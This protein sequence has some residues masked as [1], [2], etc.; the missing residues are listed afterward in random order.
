MKV[1]N[2]PKKKVHSD[3]FLKTFEQR[4]EL[5]YQMTLSNIDLIPE[6]KIEN[7]KKIGEG[8]EATVY[9]AIYDGEIVAIKTYKSGNGMEESKKMLFLKNK[10]ILEYKRSFYREINNQ[11]YF[12]SMLEY[13]EHGSL[14]NKK[15]FISESILLKILED[16][17][18][19]LK[20][21]HVDKNVIH[22]DIKPDNILIFNY[23]EICDVNAKLSDFGTCD[24][25]VHEGNSGKD[26]GTPFFMAPEVVK[27]ETYTNKCDIYSFGITML[28]SFLKNELKESISDNPQ[29]NGTYIK[30][31][32]HIKA[33]IRNLIIKCCQINPLK[34]PD[35][36]ECLNSIQKISKIID[37]KE[38]FQSTHVKE[39]DIKYSLPKFD[40]LE[41]IRNVVQS[42]KELKVTNKLIK[43]LLMLKFNIQ[44]KDALSFLQNN[45]VS[46]ENKGDGDGD[47]A[48]ACYYLKKND[49]NLMNKVYKLMINAASKS[50]PNAIMY[51]IDILID[52]V[53][54]KITIYDEEKNQICK[55]INE[56]YDLQLFEIKNRIKNSIQQTNN[57]T[58]STTLVITIFS[59]L[60]KYFPLCEFRYGIVLLHGI[61][62]TK[63][64][65]SAKSIFNSFK[66][67]DYCKDP[68]E[69]EFYYSYCKFVK[70]NNDTYKEAHDMLD[71]CVTYSK[72]Q[73]YY[74]D[75]LNNKGVLLYEGLN[76]KKDINKAFEYFK[77]SMKLNNDYGRYNYAFCLLAHKQILTTESINKNGLKIIKELANNGLDVAQEY[78]EKACL[79]GYL[80]LK[81]Y[82]FLQEAIYWFAQ[83]SLQLDY[84]SI[85]NLGFYLSEWSEKHNGDDQKKCKE[86]AF[87]LFKIASQNGNLHAQL[88]LIKCYWRGIGTRR[89]LEETK[90][91]CQKALKNSESNEVAHEKLKIDAHLQYLTIL[92]EISFQHKDICIHEDVSKL[93]ETIENTNYPDVLYELGLCYHNNILVEKDINKAIEYYERAA[94]LNN[95]NALYNLGIIFSNGDGIEKDINK[96]IDYYE[97]ASKLNDSNAL[98]DLGIIYSNG[99][100]VEKDIN[101]AIEYLERAVALNHEQANDL[102][103]QIKSN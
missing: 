77:K 103:K 91:W 14:E 7:L 60:G 51:L 50:H 82:N 32:G 87:N 42:I 48:S 59:V 80:E 71:K 62:V 38:L 88:K 3:E 76:C 93:I 98:N 72:N 9:R 11:K 96:A 40:L 25:V 57:H 92:K 17:C 56:I 95:S 43:S 64:I 83:E 37:N 4:I 90:S 54:D 66:H 20:Y 102:L 33:D 79:I 84:F 86:I 39:Y 74:S 18:K 30:N 41:S 67:S 1:E 49:P 6:D 81:S 22:R 21:L 89:N 47:Y 55:I 63:N 78:F 26:I 36:N 85:S 75:A 8:G 97:R 58:I 61:G 44:S 2:L 27:G 73:Y 24:V 65:E 23:N 53:D 10:Y 16:I 31:T 35:I 69:I 28:N 52:I 100:G 46:I 34:R 15:H 19:A 70:N 29:Q 12:C 68:Q 101:K 99:D 45:Y 94:N 13:A 5:K